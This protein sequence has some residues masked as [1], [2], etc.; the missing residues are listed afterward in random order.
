MYNKIAAVVLG[1]V[2]LWLY[3]NNLFNRKTI[4]LN[5]S[6]MK[7]LTNNVIKVDNKCYRIDKTAS[8]CESKED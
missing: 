6:R 5:S 8:K 1:L 7:K 3:G 2:L 4:V